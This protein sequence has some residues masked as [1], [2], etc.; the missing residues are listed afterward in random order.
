MQYVSLIL[1]CL[2]II[3]KCQKIYTQFEKIFTYIIL[4]ILYC[5]SSDGRNT[6]SYI[7]MI[8]IMGKLQK[9][10]ITKPL[11]RMFCLFLD[12][13]L[14]YNQKSQLIKKQR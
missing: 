4:H 2:L 6:V 13:L 3:Y 12:V 10:Q 11:M 1:V 14:Y 9:R 8:N 7:L 5:R